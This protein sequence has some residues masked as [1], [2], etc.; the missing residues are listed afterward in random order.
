M[1]EIS[2]IDDAQKRSLI[3][4][5]GTAIAGIEKGLGI[6]DVEAQL[7]ALLGGSLTT[8]RFSP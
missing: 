1:I 5:L 3:T 4:D 8:V 2:V 6:T 7:D